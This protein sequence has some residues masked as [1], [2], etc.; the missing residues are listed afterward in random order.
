MAVETKDSAALI[1]EHEE[2]KYSAEEKV[3]QMSEVPQD[4]EV[5]REKSPEMSDEKED[6][7]E[8]VI[9]S[10]GV[11]TTPP[12][13]RSPSSSSSEGPGEDSVPSKVIEQ[14]IMVENSL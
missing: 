5:S 1:F 11:V 10:A 6:E 9:P 7:R 14:K 13:Q 3:I 12:K 2:T 8:K 4:V